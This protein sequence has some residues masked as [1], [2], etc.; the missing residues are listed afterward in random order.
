[1]DE[2]DN[3]TDA[4]EPNFTQSSNLRHEDNYFSSG[5]CSDVYVD[6][7]E[8][9]DR[10]I[11][12]SND[13][14]DDKHDYEDVIDVCNLLHDYDGHSINS[15]E[16]TFRTFLSNSNNFLF[17]RS[18]QTTDETV[19]NLIHLY[20]KHRMT[21]SNLN[22]MLIVINNM[23][24][25]PN[26]MPKTLHTLFHYVKDIAPFCIVIKHF[27]CKKFLLYKGV[28]TASEVCKTCLIN[29]NSFFF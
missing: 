1:M 22:D 18:A 28:D 12:E 24:P 23:L 13:I 8:V 4:T 5:N 7:D 21:K 9:L 15:N 25:Q 10:E 17:D 16:S 27:Y 14:V 20:I 26:S 11:Y 2:K 3:E 6:V 29:E 19:Y